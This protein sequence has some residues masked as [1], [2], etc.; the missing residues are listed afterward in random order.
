MKSVYKDR[1][2]IHMSGGYSRKRYA[3]AVKP[4]LKGVPVEGAEQINMCSIQ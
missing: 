1:L 4:V 3:T 2:D